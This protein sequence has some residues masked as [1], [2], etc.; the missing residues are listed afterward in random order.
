MRIAWHRTRDRRDVTYRALCFTLRDTET[1][2]LR[3]G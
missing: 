3:S 1:F 2:R